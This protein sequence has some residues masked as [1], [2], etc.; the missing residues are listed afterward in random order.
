M[1]KNRQSQIYEVKSNGE[2]IAPWGTPEE[3]EK[4]L[5]WIV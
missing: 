4:L 5:E 3:V 2:R 1:L